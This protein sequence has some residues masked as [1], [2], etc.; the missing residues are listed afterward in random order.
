MPA[1][2][3]FTSMEMLHFKLYA[4]VS[5]CVVKGER[6]HARLVSRTMSHNETLQ[7]FLKCHLDAD[8]WSQAM[9]LVSPRWFRHPPR[10]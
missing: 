3:S 8:Q 6:R 9:R 5:S 1:A 4:V 2:R 10:T 7:P